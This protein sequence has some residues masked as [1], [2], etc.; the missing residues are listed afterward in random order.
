MW[1]FR[2]SWCHRLGLAG[3]LVLAG[4]LS[5]APDPVEELRQVLRSE[6]ATAEQREKTLKGLIDRLRGMG[7]LRRALMLS[8]WKETVPRPPAIA[9]ADAAARAQIAQRFV[10]QVEAVVA[11]LEFK[12]DQE[13]KRKATARLAVANMIAEMGPNVAGLKAEEIGGFTRTL[14]KSMK[15][16]AEDARAGQK[17]ASQAVRWEALRALGRINADPDIAVPELKS[18]LKDPDL[19][20]RRVAADSLGQMVRV[21]DYLR[22]PGRKEMRVHAGPRDVVAVASRV[23]DASREGLGD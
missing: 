16:L 21:V 20:A 14:A 2:Q 13:R 6:A 19:G 12:D 17:A 10:K 22:K 23:V 4:A 8:E 5:A 11:D 7:D 1:H 3:V 18:A 15:K 9:E